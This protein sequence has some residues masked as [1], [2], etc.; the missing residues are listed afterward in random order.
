MWRTKT[1]RRKTLE[2]RWGPTALELVGGVP[3]RMDGSEGDGNDLD[4]EVPITDKDYRE[5]IRDEVRWCRGGCTP[6]T[7]MWRSMATQ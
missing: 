3:W 5:K 4:T 2:E 1:V 6:R 7:A